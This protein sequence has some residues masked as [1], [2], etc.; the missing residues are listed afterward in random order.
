MIDPC[1]QFFVTGSRRWLRQIVVLLLAVSI[2]SACGDPGTGGSGVPTANTGATDN[3]SGRPGSGNAEAPAPGG[4]TT[5]AQGSNGNSNTGVTPD[6]SPVTAPVVTP[7]LSFTY[8]VIAAIGTTF[9]SVPPHSEVQVSGVRF[10]LSLAVLTGEDGS[11]RTVDQLLAG[12]PISLGY[13]A[14]A[15]LAGAAVGAAG[16]AVRVDRAT[17][18]DPLAGQL[19]S[20]P[21]PARVLF[22]T[23]NL[24]SVSADLVRIGNATPANPGNRVRAWIF[25]RGNISLVSRLEFE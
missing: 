3:V 25:T 7:A 10:D 19:I 18:A 1:P 11:A 4:G 9:I 24:V 16:A 21:A 17:L 22:D 8:G 14:S 2:I 23:G 5:P 20:E 13:S 6:T 12:V 15:D